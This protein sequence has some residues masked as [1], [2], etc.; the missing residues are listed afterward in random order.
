MPIWML[1]RIL[2]SEIS[3][4][5]PCFVVTGHIWIPIKEMT[6]WIIT[7]ATEFSKIGNLVFMILHATRLNDLAFGTKG[8]PQSPGVHSFCLIISCKVLFSMGFFLYLLA[9]SEIL[10]NLAQNV[11][12][13]QR[14]LNGKDFGSIPVLALLWI[15]I[16]KISWNSIIVL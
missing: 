12:W 7:K 10:R 9:N 11:M 3:D 2:Y 13:Y 15:N 1:D 16:L 4:I 6:T 5:C 8:M 14:K